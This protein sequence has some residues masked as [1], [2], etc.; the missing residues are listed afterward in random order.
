M[1][2]FIRRN[3]VLILAVIFAVGIV[4][5]GMN[6]DSVVSFVVSKIFSIL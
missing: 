5:L 4:V 3:W 6:M 1:S 2:W